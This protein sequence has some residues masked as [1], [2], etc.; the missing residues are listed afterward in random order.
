MYGK[1][2]DMKFSDI[3]G[4]DTLK[5]QLVSSLSSGKVAHAQLF[6]G[7]ERTAMLPLAL[8]Y[9]SYLMC[10]NKTAEDSCGSCANCERMAKFIHPDIHWYFPKTAS[11]TSTKYDK[12]LAEALPLWRSFMTQLPFGSFD[13]WAH[14]YNQENKFLQ[15]SREDS[16]QIMKDVSMRSVEG[17]HKVIFIWSAEY[18]HPAGANALLKVLEEPPNNTLFLLVSS[19][20][21]SLLQTI[22]SR[23]LLVN[24]P[25]HT[26][27]EVS[28]YLQR[29]HQLEEDQASH[30]ADIA[31]GSIGLAKKLIDA[32]HEMSHERFRN[33]MLACWKKDVSSLVKESEAF[34]SE[35]KASQRG[36]LSLSLSIIR[37]ATVYLGGQEPLLQNQGELDFIKK[38]S[39]QLG[40]EKLG[41]VY[42][43]IND[44][45]QH[46]E[47]N[48]NPRITH[49]NLSLDLLR[50]ING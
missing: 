5:A 21:E 34:S 8:A 35:A 23:T 49:L 14:H 44:A 27:E 25:P 43:L 38:F 17:G 50:K 46:L 16:R 9:A 24:V 28:D 22:R 31:N 13:D 30:L 12:V 47:R 11:S 41:M 6:A 3:P 1:R 10:E 2:I 19:S 40:L 26:K 42:S 18:M 4:L 29:Q 32:D 15:L 45:M 48:A 36:F 20:Y 37:N 33:W 7:K 39:S